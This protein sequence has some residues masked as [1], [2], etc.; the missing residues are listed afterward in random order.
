MLNE[1]QSDLLVLLVGGPVKRTYALRGPEGIHIG[2]CLD[3][4]LDEFQV[5]TSGSNEEWADLWGGG[6][7]RMTQA[8]TGE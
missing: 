7:G 8:V 3:E 4:D 5:A 2:P 1:Q 6:R